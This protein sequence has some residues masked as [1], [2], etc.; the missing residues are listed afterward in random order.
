MPARDVAHR[1]GVRREGAALSGRR[2]AVLH[3]RVAVEQ[4]PGHVGL[5]EG[6]TA[7]D[8]EGRPDGGALL[9]VDDPHRRLDLQLRLVR[10]RLRHV[11]AE[12]ALQRDAVHA[13]ELHGEPL[14]HHGLGGVDELLQ[15]ESGSAFRQAGGSRRDVGLAVDRDPDRVEEVPGAAEAGAH[16]R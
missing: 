4:L 8:G 14:L 3:D 2:E 15:R 6:A 1:E 12:Q 7:L 5:E 10:H 11:D 13:G 16:R 9:R